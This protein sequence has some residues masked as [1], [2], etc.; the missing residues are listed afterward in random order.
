MSAS[1]SILTLISTSDHSSVVIR[2]TPFLD[3]CRQVG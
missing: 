3:Y 2:I 1:D